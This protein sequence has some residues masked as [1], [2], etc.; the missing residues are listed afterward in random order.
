MLKTQSSLFV[1][2]LGMFWL[3]LSGCVIHV[4]SDGI[5]SNYNGVSSVFG[6]VSVSEGKTVG[7]VSSVNGNVE[8]EDYV[9]ADKVDTV[10]GSIEVGRH[11]AVSEATTVNGDIETG[12]EFKSEGKVETVN[13]EINIESMSRVKGDIATVNGDIVLRNVVA[14]GNVYTKNGD[15]ALTEK[16]LIKGDLIYGRRG[17]SSNRSLP[18]LTISQ[19]SDVQGEI[20]LKRPV[21][22]RIQNAE[23]LEKVR[24]LYS[25]E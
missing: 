3:T 23:L 12:T 19:D 24:Y 25:D 1:T 20:V 13:G 22:L 16:T 4:G 9:T 7:D 11:V 2:C 18:V 17:R 10:N 15:M 14:S 6:E 21:T 8:L 5:D